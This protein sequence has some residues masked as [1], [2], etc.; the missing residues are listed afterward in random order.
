MPPGS[1]PPPKSSKRDEPAPAMS[2]PIRPPS[3]EYDHAE[4]LVEPI[5][6]PFLYTS[7]A[8]SENARAPSTSPLTNV[9][10]DSVP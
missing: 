10:G 9:C 8:P 3:V 5:R 2:R 4:T 6:V 1:E 7:T